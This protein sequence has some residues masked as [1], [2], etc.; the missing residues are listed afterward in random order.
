MRRTWDPPATTRSPGWGASPSVWATPAPCSRTSCSPRGTTSRTTDD[1]KIV[2]TGAASDFFVDPVTIN[3][4][5]NDEPSSKVILSVSPSTLAEAANSTSVR[6]TARLDGAVLASD[7]VVTLALSGTAGAGDYT[8]STLETITITAGQLSAFDDFDFDPTDDTIDEGDETITVGGSATQSL[9]VDSADIT[10]T[11]DPAD[12]S[13]DTVTLS[14]D[15]A[16]IA[17]NETGTTTVTVT[18]R[19]RGRDGHGDPLHRHGGDAE[20]VAGRHSRRGHERRLHQ[21]LRLAVRGSA[22]GSRS[23]RGA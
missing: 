23:R 8:V 15:D 13:S 20:R 10:I 17:E 1:E 7:V 21:H 3:I 14:V 9:S 11:D 6:V 2:I 19:I 18:A 5:D 4:K 16:S 22:E 12:V